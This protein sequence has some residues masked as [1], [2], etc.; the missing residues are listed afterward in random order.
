MLGIVTRKE[1]WRVSCPVR[2]TAIDRKLVGIFCSFLLSNLS[3]NAEYRLLSLESD[4]TFF[5][6]LLYEVTAIP[7]SLRST[8]F[9]P[10]NSSFL[11]KHCGQ[12]RELQKLLRAAVE[13][14]TVSVTRPGT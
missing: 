5:R 7:I 10:S 4:A 12:I 3:L 2:V 13:Q 6:C 8:R 1:Q 14:K 11:K 9:P